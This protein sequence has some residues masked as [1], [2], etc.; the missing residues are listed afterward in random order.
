M[1]DPFDLSD[2]CLRSFRRNL[3]HAVT[4]IEGDLAQGR[5]KETDRE[6][7]DAIDDLIYRARL[8]GIALKEIDQ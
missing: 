1:S 3:E 4:G 5:I 7:M 6:I 2:I 8:A